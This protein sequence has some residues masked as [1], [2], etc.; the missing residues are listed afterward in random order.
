MND[1]K[2]SVLEDGF[3][4]RAYTV[5]ELALCYNPHLTQQAACRQLRRWI[6]FHP[7]L[8]RTLTQL[9][10]TPRVRCFTPKQV[11]AIVQAL[12]EP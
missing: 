9:G 11:A 10:H 3:L 7:E 6:N 12:G 4:V 2:K 1:L 8:N 5:S